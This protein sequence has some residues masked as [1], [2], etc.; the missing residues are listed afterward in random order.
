M[1]LVQERLNRACDALNSAHVPYAVV[2]AMP[3]PLGLQPLTM[4]LF[5]IQGMLI[6]YSREEDLPQAT[7]ALEKCRLRP[8]Y[9]HGNGRVSRRAQWK[10]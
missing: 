3:L 5:A 4:V 9:G 1:E 7:E 6:C 8:G 10:T 2:E